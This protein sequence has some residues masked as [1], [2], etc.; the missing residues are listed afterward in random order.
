MNEQHVAHEG[1]LFFSF[2]G[3]NSRHYIYDTAAHQRC[4][5]RHV[6]RDIRLDLP[7][8]GLVPVQNLTAAN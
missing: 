1:S 2:E 6:T 7:D 8:L 4:I 5:S 3:G